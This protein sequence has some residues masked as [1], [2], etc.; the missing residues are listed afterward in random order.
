LYLPGLSRNILREMENHQAGHKASLQKALVDEKKSS[1]N[2]YVDLFVGK[3]GFWQI[4]KY[5][6]I[7]LLFSWIHGAWDSFAGKYFTH[8]FF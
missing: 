7:L 6:L 4:L 2:K 5:E 8:V 1:K 3:Q